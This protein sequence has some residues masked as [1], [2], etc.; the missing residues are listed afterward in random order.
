[1]NKKLLFAVAAVLL[2]SGC[3]S[4]IRYVVGAE[5]VFPLPPSTSMACVMIGTNAFESQHPNNIRKYLSNE[6]FMQG[7]THYK[8]VSQEGGRRIT[9]AFEMYR[10]K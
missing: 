2:V 10:C 5:A 3:T 8:V 7:G 1:M 9:G 6:T 4:K